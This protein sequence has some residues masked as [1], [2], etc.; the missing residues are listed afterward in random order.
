[1][2]SY[3]QIDIRNDNSKNISFDISRGNLSTIKGS[4][5]N[6]LLRASFILLGS[7]KL[8]EEMLPGGVSS[9]EH[10]LESIFICITSAINISDV[11]VRLSFLS[12]CYL[13]NSI[14]DEYLFKGSIYFIFYWINLYDCLLNNNDLIKISNF[15][16]L[17]LLKLQLHDSNNNFLE[18]IISLLENIK[19]K[20]ILGEGS[21]IGSDANDLHSPLVEPFIFHNIGCWNEEDTNVK[22]KSTFEKLSLKK[23]EIFGAENLLDDS[24]DEEIE[25]YQNYSC[26]KQFPRIS[27][28]RNLFSS[29]ERF[30]NDILS[31]D[32]QELARQWTLLDHLSFRKIKLRTLLSNCFERNKSFSGKFKLLESNNISCVRRFINRFNSTSQ[33]VTNYIL[34]ASTPELR[35]SLISKFIHLAV[36]LRK[37]GNY[38][39]L[40]TIL[41][42]LQ[43]GCITR[44]E[45]T[46][47]LIPKYELQQLYELKKLMSG[48]KNY[49]NYREEI[50]TLFLNLKIEQNSKFS[51]TSKYF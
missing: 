9:W 38:N 34:N 21:Y 49:S 10:S 19:S 22:F 6:N 50:S 30:F 32:L 1:M 41:T 36:E 35:A 44:L 37:L 16:N 24:T 25:D 27:L 17:L 42:A 11:I 39:G 8:N 18:I 45:I 51:G 20:N 12:N 26:N 4:S 43:Q 13:H 2:N 15:L 47:S 29:P 31:I 40:M 46:F 33:W 14:D 28:N 7:N 23:L 3:W 5:L 48:I